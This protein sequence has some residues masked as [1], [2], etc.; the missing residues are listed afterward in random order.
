MRVVG[1][2]VA[3]RLALACSHPAPTGAELSSVPSRSLFR[4]SITTSDLGRFL[5][6]RLLKMELVPPDWLK[7]FAPD[8]P[9]L[10][11][12]ARAAVLYLAIL[13]FMRVLPRRTGG[14]VARMDLLFI[15]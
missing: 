5:A 3:D 8:A 11:L 2:A 4:A 12:V 7:V 13:A 1:E 9:L 10:E 14:E 15:R 6:R